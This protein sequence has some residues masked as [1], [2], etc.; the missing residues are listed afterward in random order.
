MG[1]AE[2]LRL[3]V[4]ELRLVLGAGHA[5]V[6]APGALVG[7]GAE[8][9]VELQLAAVRVAVDPGEPVAAVGGLLEELRVLGL[10]DAVAGVLRRAGGEARRA[11]GRAL[12][13]LL[14]G[15]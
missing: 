4:V 9:N 8:D 3:V 7:V 10:R 15:D 12:D 13:E 11:V 14:A 5:A 1:Q 6:R 2:A